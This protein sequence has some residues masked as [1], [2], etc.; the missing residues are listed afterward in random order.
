M[1][2]LP[3]ME[4]AVMEICR[5]TPPLLPTSFC[6]PP[7]VSQGARGA[8]VVIVAAA[9]QPAGQA[10]KTLR[11]VL[12]QRGPITAPRTPGGAP[13]GP[14]GFQRNNNNKSSRAAEAF[15]ADEPSAEILN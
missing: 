12:D 2:V 4:E 13:R 3:P 7:K 8:H 6:P 11:L 15:Q 1:D 10:G 9:S 5:G 14:S